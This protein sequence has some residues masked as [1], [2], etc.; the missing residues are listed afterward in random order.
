MRIAVTAPSRSLGREVPALVA[1]LAEAEGAELV[2]HPQCFLSEGHFAGPDSARAE[3][4]IEAANDPSFDAVWFARGGYGSNRIVDAVMPR[5]TQAAR[6]KTYLGYSDGGT[7]LSALHGGGFAGAAHG[8]LVDDVRREGGPAAAT[9]ALRWLVHGDPA[10]LE[11]SLADG[12]PALA[13]NL[14]IL[15][16]LLGTTW[17][18]PVQGR[19]LMLE[20][21]AEPVYRIDR[22]LAQ[23]TAWGKANGALGLRLGRCS[24]IVPN[25]PDFGREPEAVAREWCERTGLP[26]LGFAD[27]GHDADNTVV[28]FGAR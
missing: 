17:A 18:P 9:R 7:L 25:D 14:T 20:E 16:H 11:P 5:L 2:F 1:P 27:I 28:P 24:A 3:A 10:S 12:R 23:V 4:F 6:T 15:S 19:V 13:F 8:P 21:V 26:W 22:A